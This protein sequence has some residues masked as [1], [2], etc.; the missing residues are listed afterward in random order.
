MS[1]Y[2]FFHM[3]NLVG[4]VY[5]V[6]M[7]V[8]CAFDP[9]LFLDLSERERGTGGVEGKKGQRQQVFPAARGLQGLPISTLYLLLSIDERNALK[10]VF[11]DLIYINTSPLYCSCSLF[12]FSEKTHKKNKS[13]KTQQTKT[14]IWWFYF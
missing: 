3:L 13:E 12:P 7:Y 11:L 9:V 8:C 4:Y 6:C 10:S 2:F 1:F 5:Y 14:A